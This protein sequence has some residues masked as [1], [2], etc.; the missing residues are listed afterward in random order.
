MNGDEIGYIPFEY[1]YGEGFIQTAHALLQRAKVYPT[2]DRSK[3]G[4]STDFHEFIMD[5]RDNRDKFVIDVV[6]V[7]RKKDL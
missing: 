4:M 6:D 2:T 5:T 3:N 1:G 7:S